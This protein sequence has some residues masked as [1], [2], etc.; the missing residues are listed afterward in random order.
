MSE[1]TLGLTLA[2]W[3]GIGSILAIVIALFVAMRR[4]QRI[5]VRRVMVR[6]YT[7]DMIRRVLMAVIT[8]FAAIYVLGVLQVEIGPLIGGLGISGLIVAVA[9]QPLFANFVGSI[10]LHGT[11]AF[12][13]GD[14]IATNGI[15][16]TVVD[17]SHRAVEIRDF[18][19]NSAYVP[20]MR[21]LDGNLVNLTAD[22]PRRSL[23]SF[24]VAYDT[25]LRQA[26][27]VLRQAIN[28]LDGVVDSPPVLVLVRSFGDSG[29]DMEAEI[30]HPA[31][32]A[33]ARR[34]VS[35]TAITIHETLA[36]NDITIPFPQVVI[37]R[38]PDP[39]ADPAHTERSEPR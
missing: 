18:D 19:G 22:D 32:E 20:N 6:D 33:I 17:I 14:E 10:L 2:Q 34:T 25:D 15:S 12:R 30:W 31:E 7:A 16:G 5:L 3:I 11:R 4:I 36:A 38:P 23:I 27:R 13:P 35:D 37:N 28:K 21:A 24:Q 9:L 39:D 26:Q 29:V 1:V 8:L